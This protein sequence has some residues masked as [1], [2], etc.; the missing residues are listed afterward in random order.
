MHSAFVTGFFTAQPN[1]VAS[2]L[3][4]DAKMQNFAPVR[5]RRSGKNCE[6]TAQVADASTVRI[7]RTFLAPQ[8]GPLI[9]NSG[10]NLD[11][12]EP[13]VLQHRRQRLDSGKKPVVNR[14]LSFGSVL[15]VRE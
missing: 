11:L 7:R 1:C 15:D 13:D 4:A 8:D 10:K 5:L 14:F 12:I 6:S 3:S 9:I 2:V